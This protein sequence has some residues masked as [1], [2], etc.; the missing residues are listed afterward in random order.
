[1]KKI[2][3]LALVLMLGAC[4][5]QLRGAAQL[6]F[7]TLYVDG[8]GSALGV[9]LQRAL[10][11]GSN[12]QLVET[13]K[14]AQAILQVLGESREKRILSIGSN[15][16]VSEYVLFYRLSVRLHD[17]KGKE[18]LPAQPLELKRDISFNDAQVL[19]KEQEEA[20]L[21]RDMQGDAV[22]QIIRRLNAV[23]I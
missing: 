23:K 7:K 18:L 21:Y 22:Q 2:L 6:P 11:H 10:R 12:V 1:M 3:L 14:E 17:G 8:R 5:F 9:D 4:G 19:A 15:G 20:M 13:A 16:R